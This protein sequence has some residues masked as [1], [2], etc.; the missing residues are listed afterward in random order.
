MGADRLKK[1]IFILDFVLTLFY[2]Q[3]FKNLIAETGWQKR[4]INK[5]LPQMDKWL[6][7][8]DANKNIYPIAKTPI[9][10]LKN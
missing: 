3:T 9:T 7:P 5:S 6:S 4:G 1:N 10:T 2:W 8:A